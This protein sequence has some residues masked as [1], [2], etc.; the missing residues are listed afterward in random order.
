MR[1]EVAYFVDLYYKYLTEKLEV[2]SKPHLVQ[3]KTFDEW[4]ENLM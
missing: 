3:F 4:F 2:T 1:N